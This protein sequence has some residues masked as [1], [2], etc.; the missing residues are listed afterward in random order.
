MAVLAWWIVPVAIALFV[1]AIVSMW[2]KRPRI[3]GAFEDVEHFHRFLITLKH[4]STESTRR[5]GG[6]TA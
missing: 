6:P 4:H 3:R 1:G 2:G 5:D